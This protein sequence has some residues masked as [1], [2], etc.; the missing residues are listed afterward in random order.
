[1]QK[2]KAICCGWG[3]TVKKRPVGCGF[4]GANKVDEVKMGEN[5]LCGTQA[6]EDSVLQLDVF[7]AYHNLP[8]CAERERGEFFM[9]FYTAC[10]AKKML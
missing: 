1:M 2:K 8:G 6:N 9:S 3:T 5:F 7:D 4:N 10:R